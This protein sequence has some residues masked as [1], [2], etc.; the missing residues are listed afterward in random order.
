MGRPKTKNIISNEII[1]L[2]FEPLRA[3]VFVFQK[4]GM[5]AYSKTLWK[6]FCQRNVHACIKPYIYSTLQITD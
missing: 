6:S 3:V 2:L 5:C 4:V 1:P